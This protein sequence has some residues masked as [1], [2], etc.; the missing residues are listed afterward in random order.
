MKLCKRA[1][2]NYLLL[3]L[4]LLSHLYHNNVTVCHL[5]IL[6][7]PATTITVHEFKM[8]PNV[9]YGMI[10]CNKQESI[11]LGCVPAAFLLVGSTGAPCRQTIPFESR[12]PAVN[13]MTDT[14]KNI[15]L[16]QTL[17]ASG[18]NR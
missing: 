5:P 14:C 10:R 15:T 4:L 8:S 9:Y 12:P 3:L 1:R 18:K 6:Q 2:I 11:P 13:R 16:P 17:F 7:L